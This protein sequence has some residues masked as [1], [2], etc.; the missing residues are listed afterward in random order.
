MN[1]KKITKK[2]EQYAEEQYDLGHEAGWDEG[3]SSGYD[4]GYEGHKKTMGFRLSLSYDTAM[5]KNSFREAKL[6][7]EM[8]EYLDFEFTEDPLNSVDNDF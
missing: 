7:K 5:S 3:F 8:I 4:S 2:I 1:I 6:I